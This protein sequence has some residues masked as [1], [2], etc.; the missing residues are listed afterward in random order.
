MKCSKES[1]AESQ[2]YSNHKIYKKL[3][4]SQAISLS[5]SEK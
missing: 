5:I 1:F 4:F 3:I 2:R